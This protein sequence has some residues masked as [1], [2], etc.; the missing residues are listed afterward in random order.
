MAI[1]DEQM[2]ERFK[3]SS[4]LRD[5]ELHPIAEVVLC[6]LEDSASSVHL[7]QR[8]M[9]IACFPHVLYCTALAETGQETQSLVTTHLST[10]GEIY[11]RRVHAFLLYLRDLRSITLHRLY[12]RCLAQ[13]SSFQFL[14][15][16]GT[17]DGDSDTRAD[18]TAHLERH[19]GVF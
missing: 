18:A 9:T 5:T 15:G 11:I 13:L 10:P 19:P 8:F 7:R 14:R 12:K 4:G 1:A 16:P 3:A 2:R 17:Q 6:S